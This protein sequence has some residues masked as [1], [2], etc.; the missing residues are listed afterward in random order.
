MPAAET[1]PAPRR[2][3][4]ERRSQT[5]GKLLDATI[6][7]LATRGYSGTSTAAICAEA[8]VSQGALFRHFPTRRAVLVATAEHVAHLQVATFRARFAGRAYDA[9]ALEAALVEMT[10]LVSSRENRTWHEL[11]LAASSDEALLGELRPAVDVY[12]REVLAAAAEF[13]GAAVPERRLVPVMTI[14]LNFLDGLA[15]S[16]PLARSRARVDEAVRL[17]A[18]ML[19]D[20][21]DRPVTPDPGARA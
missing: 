5:V 21:D 18:A 13:F 6:E 4:H 19:H 12:H 14:V 17:L 15:F 7:C 10:G 16:A 2:T 11:V 3:Q 9:G 20:L 1:T 8:G